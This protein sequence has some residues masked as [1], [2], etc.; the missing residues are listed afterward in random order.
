MNLK[1]SL[2]KLCPVVEAFLR[3]DQIFKDKGDP[4]NPNHIQVHEESIK[5][6]VSYLINL[7]S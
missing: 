1:K 3:H 7:E 5:K 4:N 2:A 6:E